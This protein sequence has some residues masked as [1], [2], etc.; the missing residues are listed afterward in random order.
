MRLLYSDCTT[1]CSS[2]CY[3]LIFYGKRLSQMAL[4]VHRSDVVSKTR[5]GLLVITALLE[6]V[7]F[8]VS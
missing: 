1:E 5:N 8:R 3:L 2:Y 4:A 6:A 7:I